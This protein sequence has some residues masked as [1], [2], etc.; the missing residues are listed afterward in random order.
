MRARSREINIFNMSLLDILCGALGAFCFMML[1]LLPYYKPPDSAIDLKKERATTDE[2]VKELERLKDA[3]KNSE[4][5][6]DME[7]LLK[8]L[9]ET[10]K[11]LQGELNQ[12]A[13]ENERLTNENTSLSKQ[14]Q[15]QKLDLETRTPFVV[16]VS[17]NPPLD[18]DVYV[19]DSTTTQ[20][21]DGS[22]H[23]NPP[24]NPEQSRHKSFWPGDITTISYNGVTSWMVRDTPAS[25]NYKVYVKA[26]SGPAARVS[27][28]V[29]GGVHG[30]N[31]GWF[32]ELP[33]VAI[34]PQRF[35]TLMGTLA[36]DSEGK[37]YFKEATQQER[38]AEWTKISKTAPPAISSATPATQRTPLPGISKEEMDRRRDEYIRR[39]SQGQNATA[40]PIP[41]KSP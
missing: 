4:L 14:N 30:P 34:T 40:S 2:L 37:M 16:T 11:R 20:N 8:K 35:W 38:D 13:H 25:A 28:T 9:Q 39:R 36:K 32:I 6:H 29:E 3:A 21:A 31:N 33:K 24:F 23:R 1:V 7:E 41:Q 18:L 5:S 10:I 15:Q 27:T 12:L 19:D 22:A 26:A 17:A